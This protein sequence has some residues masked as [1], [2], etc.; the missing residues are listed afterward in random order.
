ML[1]PHESKRIEREPRVEAQRLFLEDSVER[2][3]VGS[4][5]WGGEVKMALME[6]GVFVKSL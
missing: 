3:S 5:R 2:A 1:V 6:P 4:P